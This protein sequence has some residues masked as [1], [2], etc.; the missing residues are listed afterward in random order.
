MA[1]GFIAGMANSLKN[2]RQLLRTNKDRRKYAMEH[3]AE[4]KVHSPLKRPRIDP[5]KLRKLV[6]KIR[7]QAHEDH[8]KQR[9]VLIFILFIT[10]LFFGFLYVFMGI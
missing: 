3:H 9:L 6:N 10:M 1:G 2:N 5:L 7:S 4:K 8:K